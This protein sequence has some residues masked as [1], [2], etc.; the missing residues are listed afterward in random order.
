MFL[1][2]RSVRSV[3][4]QGSPG[5]VR[6]D[7]CGYIHPHMYDPP[8]RDPS[9]TLHIY[10]YLRNHR[11]LLHHYRV[12]RCSCNRTNPSERS[13]RI[14]QGSFLLNT[15][16]LPTCVLDHRELHSEFLQGSAE[17]EEE[18]NGHANLQMSLMI[19]TTYRL[20]NSPRR[21]SSTMLY[22]LLHLT[23]PWARGAHLLP[24]S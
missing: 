17:Q 15:P 12:S 5:P 21:R 3:L 7:Q 8:N 20:D 23:A 16:P 18:G 14:L 4:R 24:W 10:Y 13:I 9:D 22:L 19:H 6:S 2:G 1:N 11:P